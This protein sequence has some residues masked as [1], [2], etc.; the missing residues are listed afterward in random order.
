MPGRELFD[1]L[2]SDG[3]DEDDVGYGGGRSSSYDETK[4]RTAAGA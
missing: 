2:F 3:D 4:M 1:S